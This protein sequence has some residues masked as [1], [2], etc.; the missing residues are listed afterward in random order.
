M[1]SHK[2]ARLRSPHAIVYLER[3]ITTHACK[4]GRCLAVTMTHLLD[5]PQE[6]R[7][8]KHHG[9]RVGWICWSIF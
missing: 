3:I 8:Q 4:P 9:L 7:F 6:V 1:L 5:Q 2:L